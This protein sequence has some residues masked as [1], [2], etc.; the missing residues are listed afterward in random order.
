MMDSHKRVLGILYIV[1]GITQ[2]ILMLLLAAFLSYFIPLIAGEADADARWVFEWI[3]PFF[4]VIAG[5]VI[6]FFSIPSIIGG[7]AVLNEKSWGLTLVLV[8][9]CFKL[10]SFPIGTAIGIYTIWVCAETKRNTN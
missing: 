4:N 9:G 6:V 7:I 8:L 5:V 1:T 3:L 10:L 2:L